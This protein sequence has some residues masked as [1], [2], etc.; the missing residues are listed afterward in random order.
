M[1][2]DIGYGEID[3][4]YPSSLETPNFDRLCHQSVRLTDYHVG[5]T[6]SPSRGSIMTGR[7]INAGNVWHTIAGREILRENE[8]TMA[9]VFRAN[10]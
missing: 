4:L 1:L 8:Q 10:G 5:T 6:C 7:A 2:D 3:T 9:E